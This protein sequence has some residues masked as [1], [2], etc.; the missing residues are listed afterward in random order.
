MSGKK[1]YNFPMFLSAAKF[2]RKKGHK[3]FCPAEEDLKEWGTLDNVIKKANYRVC[4][5]KDLNKILDWAT[6]IALLP[7]WK[8]SRGAK[9]EYALAQ[10]LKL[11][12]RFIQIK[13]G[14]LKLK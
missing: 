12:V 3:V 14:K 5:R 4:L 2:L 6:C 10:V 1:D 13:K 11:K 8:R 9:I 7:G